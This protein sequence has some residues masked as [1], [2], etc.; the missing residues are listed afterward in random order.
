M[1]PADGSSAGEGDTSSS[2]E[3]LAAIDGS[4]AA[5]AATYEASIRAAISEHESKQ[6][7]TLGACLLEPGMQGAGG[8]LLIDPLFQRTLVTVRSSPGCFGYCH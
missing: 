6:G 8:M 2:Y 3:A 7:V 5:T 1:A 4:R